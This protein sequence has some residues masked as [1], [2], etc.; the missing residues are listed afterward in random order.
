MLSDFSQEQKGKTPARYYPQNPVL[1][2]PCY[3]RTGSDRPKAFGLKAVNWN[4]SEA[5]GEAAVRISK[6][7][8]GIQARRINSEQLKLSVE[9]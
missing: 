6:P 1:S 5:A 7:I 2:R 3:P 4:G 8:K 9:R